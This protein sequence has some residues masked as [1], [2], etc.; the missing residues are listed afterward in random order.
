MQ[1]LVRTRKKKN[2]A[3]QSHLY[4]LGRQTARGVASWGLPDVRS[5]GFGG[6]STGNAPGHSPRGQFGSLKLHANLYSGQN[7]QKHR[8]APPGGARRTPQCYPGVSRGCRSRIRPPF[9]SLSYSKGAKAAPQPPSYTSAGQPRAP[10]CVGV[11]TCDG[12]SARLALPACSEAAM[13][14][15]AT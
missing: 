14:L 5:C 8:P 7:Q 3:K 15:Y 9:G 1:F 6:R 2:S 12:D 4:E 10:S 11:A 13:G